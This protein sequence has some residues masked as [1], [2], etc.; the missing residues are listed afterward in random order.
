MR[1]RGDK[2]NSIK[3]KNYNEGGDK[4]R[5]HDWKDYYLYNPE[6]Y[7]IGINRECFSKTLF[8]QWIFYALWHAAIIFA[9]VLLVLN[10]ERAM[11]SDGKDIGFWVCGM[12]IYGVCIFVANFELA[13]R[14]NTHTWWSTV[15]LLAGV[16]AY[17]FF[18]SILSLIFKGHINHL[19]GPSF[20]I[21]LLWII[22][23]F[24][25]MQTYVVEK[26]Y[27]EVAAFIKRSK[28]EKENRAQI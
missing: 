18:Y 17:F 10:N 25:L 22:I 5:P 21:P 1:N 2:K 14:F 26:V 19:F 15:T 20:S 7:S 3:Q 12:A 23:L 24:C 9:T 6:L 8:M 13:I 28:E 4:F 27:K 16:V 11:Q